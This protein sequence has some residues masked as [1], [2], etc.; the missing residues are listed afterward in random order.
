M[1]C[2]LSMTGAVV[3][4]CLHWL[5]CENFDFPHPYTLLCCFGSKYCKVNSPLLS[6][7]KWTPGYSHPLLQAALEFI[8]L[9]GIISVLASVHALLGYV[10]LGSQA[11]QCTLCF[12]FLFFLFS[13]E[14]P[15]HTQLTWQTWLLASQSIRI[16]QVARWPGLRRNKADFNMKLIVPIA[17]IL[18]LKCPWS[19]KWFFG[20]SF[21]YMPGCVIQL[22]TNAC[23][24]LT[25]IALSLIS[26]SK[27]HY[28]LFQKNS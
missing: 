7:Q 19:K 10:L 13:V 14:I 18:N 6:F 23:Q 22:C 11:K 4:A 17:G 3:A 8:L 5:Y 24:T 20:V 21:P 28:P 15:L 25:R 27:F 9:N 1:V 12:W 16:I 2:R 26:I